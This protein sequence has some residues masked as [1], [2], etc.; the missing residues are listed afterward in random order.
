MQEIITIP[1]TMSSLEIANLTGK[2]HKHIIRD[3]SKMT[4]DL[5][6]PDVDQTKI[7]GIEIIR[8]SRGYVY[9]IN[10]DKI[11]TLTLIT[12]YDVKR[13]HAI[14]K[15][16]L[17]LEAS[18]DKAPVLT[19][20]QQLIALATGLLE[21]DKQVKKLTKEKG[22]IRDTQLASTMAKLSHVSHHILIDEFLEEN[23]KKIKHLVSVKQMALA[24]G[25]I[26]DRK[27][28]SMKINSTLCELGL[29]AKETTDANKLK[30]GRKEI[31]LQYSW[32]LTEEGQELAKESY[33]MIGSGKTK[34]FVVSYHW[35]KIVTIK[36]INHL[37]ES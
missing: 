17:E 9:D 37:E 26:L 2:Q 30:F 10:L 35:P 36:I 3:I 15:R 1:V 31:P 16:W 12:G 13:R 28:S 18:Q 24:A 11:H 19:I 6:G 7:D 8:D 32:S 4:V 33:I 29:M 23:K 34:K 14:N 25:D 22:Q 27:I 5:H 20:D 21:K